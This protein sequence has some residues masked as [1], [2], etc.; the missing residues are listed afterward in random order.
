MDVNSVGNP[1]VVL[2]WK[3]GRRKGFYFQEGLGIVYYDFGENRRI[4]LA[5]FD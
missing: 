3:D 5:T 4:A 2:K 1:G